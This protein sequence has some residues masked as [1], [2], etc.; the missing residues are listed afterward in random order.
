MSL[1]FVKELIKRSAFMKNMSGTTD[2][3]VG[4]SVGIATFLPD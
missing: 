4:L 1:R 2:K 3:L